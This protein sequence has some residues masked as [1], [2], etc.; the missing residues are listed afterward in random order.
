M[1]AG[2]EHNVAV[3]PVYPLFLTFS[4]LILKLEFLTQFLASND[5]KY[6]YVL[7]IGISQFSQFELLFH[8]RMLPEIYHSAAEPIIFEILRWFA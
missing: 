8:N 6:F 2:Y 1:Y 5:K 3:S 7:K 4:F